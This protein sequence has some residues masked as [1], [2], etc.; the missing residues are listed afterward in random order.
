MAS[1]QKLF[2]DSNFVALPKTKLP[3]LRQVIA[4][5]P[6]HHASL[7]HVERADWGLKHNL[8]PTQRNSMIVVSRQDDPSTHALQYRNGAPY[9]GRL[10]RFKEIFGPLPAEPEIRQRTRAALPD[11][12]QRPPQPLGRYSPEAWKAVVAEARAKGPAV[13]A[14][15]E[16]A[17]TWCAQL[18]VKLDST[19]SVVMHSR[20]PAERCTPMGVHP[21]T[22]LVKESSSGAERVVHGT[23]LNEVSTQNA[24]F[25]AVGVAGFVAALAGHHHEMRKVHGQYT[26]K[27]PTFDEK[28]RMQLI[29]R[30]HTGPYRRY[31]Q[32]RN[33]H[34]ASK[35][36]SAAFDAPVSAC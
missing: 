23:M 17:A 25:I 6:S 11:P 29:L 32:N 14:D 8:P 21:P 10:Q 26:G 7:S 5:P 35:N 28:G 9:Y 4:Q 33:S 27:Y 24:R 1:F 2:R 15:P 30:E 22:Y 3:G 36:Q 19:S 20:H 18:G 34:F 12:G 16:K 31:H 13:R